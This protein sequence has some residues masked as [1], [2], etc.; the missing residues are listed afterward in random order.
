MRKNLTKKLKLEIYK[1]ILPI[2]EKKLNFAGI[3][4]H[5][6]AKL[7]EKG[8][9][10]H[11]SMNV[12]YNLPEIKEELKKQKSKE[13]LRPSSRVPFIKKQIKLLSK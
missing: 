9:D 3:C 7:R 5:F 13:Y 6:C 4:F 1:E 8:F 11:K 12:A 10:Y 2:F